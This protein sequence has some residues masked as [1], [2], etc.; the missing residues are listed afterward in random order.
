M[1]IELLR[2]FEYILFGITRR[3][4]QIASKLLCSICSM[5]QSIGVSD[6]LAILK[7]LYY[8]IWMNLEAYIHICIYVY[9]YIHIVSLE[10]T[11]MRRLAPRIEEPV[12]LIIYKKYFFFFEQ[13]RRCN[14]W[15]SLIWCHY[16]KKSNYTTHNSKIAKTIKCH[17]RKNYGSLFETIY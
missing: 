7:E 16:W 12:T 5:L 9:L 15:F 1:D 6:E 11:W 8:I 14:L 2:F 4:G 10:Y 17:D 13:N 3:E